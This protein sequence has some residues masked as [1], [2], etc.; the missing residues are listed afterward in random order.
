MNFGQLSWGAVCFYYRSLGD[1]KYTRIMR[2]TQ[3]LSRLRKEPFNISTAE[4]EEKVQQALQQQTGVSAK[5]NIDITK[6]PQFQEEW[7]KVQAQFDDQ[8]MVHLNQ[9]KQELAAVK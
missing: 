3:F 9:C 1:Q 8:Y 7:R 5:M 6:Q 2:D 4:F